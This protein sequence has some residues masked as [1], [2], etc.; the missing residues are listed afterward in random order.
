MRRP[1]DAT[2]LNGWVGD[3][4]EHLSVG[5]ENN[6]QAETWEMFARSRSSRVVRVSSVAGLR[7]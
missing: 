6:Q 4:A 1:P 3:S 7:G 5:F 2:T